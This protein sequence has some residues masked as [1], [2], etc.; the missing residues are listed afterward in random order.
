MARKSISGLSYLPGQLE[1][2][3]TRPD[4]AWHLSELAKAALRPSVPQR[5]CDHGLFSDDADQL[6]LCEMFQE[7]V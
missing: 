7:P 5:A 6:D 3:G 2:A 4:H 1:L